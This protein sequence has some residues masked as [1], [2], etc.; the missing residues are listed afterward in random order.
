[1]SPASPTS[2]VACP[3]KEL[4]RRDKRLTGRLL[5]VRGPFEERG[6]DV[7]F[8]HRGRRLPRCFRKGHEPGGDLTA[9]PARLLQQLLPVRFWPHQ[10][11]CLPPRLTDP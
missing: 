11:P 7:S 2:G 6:M 5:C 3:A 1:M 4:M 9:A 10:L 8:L